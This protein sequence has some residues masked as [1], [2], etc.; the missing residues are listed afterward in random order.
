M[1]IFTS[2]TSGEPKAVRC[3]HGKIAFPGKMLA[4]RFGLTSADTVYVSMPMFHLGTVPIER[5][6][7][8]HPAIAE[9]AVYG[10]PDPVAGD[11]IMACI[12]LR[13]GASLT[14]AELGTF[15]GAQSDIGPRQHPRFVR[16]ASQLPRTATF[17]VL[18][19]A[20][21]ADRWNTSDPVW[22]RP[23]RRGHHPGYV[24]LDGEQATSA[25]IL[26]AD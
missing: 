12:V 6:L 9:T 21:A 25:G 24:V 3:T 17:K 22:W 4:S 18:I 13:D 16:V 23:Y 10:V 19:R 26:P 20:L 7:R 14:P 8:R 11:Q 15:L 2:G 1:L 5:A